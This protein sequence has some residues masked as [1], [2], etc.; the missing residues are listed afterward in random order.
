MGKH[1]GRRAEIG[2]ADS[3]IEQINKLTEA[4][5]HALD[6]TLAAL[7]VD[8]TMGEL[9]TGSDPDVED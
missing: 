9:N 1:S 7:S 8:P 3:A 4:E 6:R 2:F 5:I